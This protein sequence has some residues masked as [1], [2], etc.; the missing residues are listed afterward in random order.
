MERYGGGRCLTLSSREVSLRS[1]ESVA[2]QGVGKSVRSR[3]TD[4]AAALGQEKCGGFGE[5][6][7]PQGWHTFI[8]SFNGEIQIELPLGVRHHSGLLG[9]A[10]DFLPLPPHQKKAAC[11]TLAH[12][13]R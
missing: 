7:S 6:G 9:P 5:R 4:S 3:G 10:G 1:W 12:A 11:V 8:H 13:Q 2:M